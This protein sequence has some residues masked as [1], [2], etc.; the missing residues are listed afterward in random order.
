MH[1]Q[2]PDD[3]ID[4]L[5]RI[6]QVRGAFRVTNTGN[7]IWW[8]GGSI[9]SPI[10][11]RII[12]GACMAGERLYSLGGGQVAGSCLDAWLRHG[13]WRGDAIMSAHLWIICA[14]I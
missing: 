2:P 8:F 4:D 1:M 3:F 14:E 12:F 6:D 11:Q 13:R 7:I 5:G 10:N 9:I